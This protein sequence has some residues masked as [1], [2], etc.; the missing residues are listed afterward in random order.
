M[1]GDMSFDPHILSIGLGM[2]GLF[3][4]I[5]NRRFAYAE[6]TQHVFTGDR[7]HYYLRNFPVVSVARV[8][9]RYFLADAWADIT[10]QPISW[11]PETG[12]LHFGYTLGRNPLQVR[13]TW[14][15]GYWWPTLEPSDPGAP[16]TLPA[17]VQNSG[18]LG[19]SEYLL[20]DVIKQAWLLQCQYVWANRDKLGY[21]LVDEA[22]KAEK[23]STLEVVPLVRTM[24][25]P[26]RRYQL[27]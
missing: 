21:G 5:C 22:G 13:V 24:I 15:G 8:E 25:E 12:L 20:P 27:T 16:G 10:G 4:S 7:P 3:D 18:A 26:Y 9:M 14:T 19:M 17:A 1:S 6:N 2:A 23:L 11:N